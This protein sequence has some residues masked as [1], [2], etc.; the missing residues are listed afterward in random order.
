MSDEEWTPEQRALARQ[1]LVE[2]RL[3]FL[4]EKMPPHVFEEFAGALEILLGA[5]E[6]MASK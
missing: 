4:R 3:D 6:H 1:W 2:K 5:W